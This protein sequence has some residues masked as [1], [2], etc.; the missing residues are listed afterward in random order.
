MEMVGCR[1]QCKCGGH[2]ELLDEGVYY[3]LTENHTI[4]FRGVCN[5]CGDGVRVERDI[6]SLML[7][8]PN[9]E[10]ERGN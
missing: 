3:I 2:V 10:G 6:L 1:V 9:K 5:T 4:I 8:C 7:S